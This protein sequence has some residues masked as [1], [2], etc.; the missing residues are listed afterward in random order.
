[1]ISALM[2][3]WRRC[4]SDG[5]NTTVSSYIDDIIGV[6]RNFSGAMELSI[7]M[8]YEAAS[9]GLS[10]KVKKCSYFPRH[11]MV[12]LGTIVDLTNFEFRVSRKRANK[13]TG[14]IRQLQD[15]AARD[16]ARVPAKLVASVVGLIWS[17][18]CCC[19]RAASVMTRDIIAVLSRSMKRSIHFGS[20]PLKA[21]LAAFWSGTVRWDAAA[22]R[23]LNF[24]SMVCFAE[25]RAPISADVLGKSI[26]LI[27]RYPRYVNWS[28]T[29]IL[30]QDASAT[31]SGGGMLRPTSTGLCASKRI[32]L[33]MF[34]S[35]ESEESS[36]LRE[37]LG[38]LNCLQATANSS[39][40]KIIFAC[41]NFQTV[42]AIKYGSKNP[43]IQFVA[44]MIFRWCLS[45]NKICWPV[46]LPRTHPVIKIGDKRSRMVIPY[47][48]QSPQSVVDAADNIAHRL[49]GR[50]LSF[51][52]TAS[53]VSAVKVNGIRLPFNAF[54]WQPGA[55]GVDSFSQLDSWKRNI[56]Y[57]YPPAPMIGRMATFLRHTYARSILVIPLNQQ[58]GWWSYA[59][60][61]GA[62]GLEHQ[63]V[64]DGF[65]ISA[66]SFVDQRPPS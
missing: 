49:W 61:P 22:Q 51:D 36:T 23:Q 25:L 30:F 10:L 52:Q 37:I 3:F 28:D 4:D 7:R 29:S 55:A 56:N 24:W 2:G 8:V 21:I 48:D 50:H 19:H 45:N 41:D 46:W 26:E 31:A 54:C 44:E 66:F 32:F 34:N 43:A 53:H 64:Q 60:A 39:K 27:F 59:V 62:R 6:T 20:R 57:V 35:Q 17:I 63:S 18:S 14:T 58:H 40:R 11:R 33:A 42:Q 5:E 16:P 65:L 1:M 15:A 47:D 38:I 9:L 13:L 12:A